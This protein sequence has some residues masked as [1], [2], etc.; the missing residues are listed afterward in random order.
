MSALPPPGA[1]RFRTPYLAESLQRAY[2]PLPTEPFHV[3]AAT[4]VWL[5]GKDAAEPGFYRPEKTPWT[6]RLQELDRHPFRFVYDFKAGRWVSVR[7][8]KFVAQKSSRTGYTEGVFNGLRWRAVYRPCNYIIAI[9]TDTQAK[10]IAAR[11]LRSLK[12]LRNLPGD[13][14]IFTGNPDD[15]RRSAFELRG[16][17]ADFY[18]SGSPGNFANKPAQRVLIDEYDEHIPSK[19]DTTSA[20]NLASRIKDAREGLLFIISKPQL[21][22][23]PI[24]T[25][26]KTG[27]CEEFFVPCPHCRTY[28]PITFDTEDLDTDF[29]FSKPFIPAEDEPS[30]GRDGA[31]R[32]SAFPEACHWP[33]PSPSDSQSSAPSH[34]HPATQHSAH[35]D[36]Q[37]TWLPHPFPP[38][39][40]AK[41]RTGR[42]K[43]DH[44]KM[45]VT[46]E[47]DMLA[48]AQGQAYYECCN[49]HCPGGDDGPRVIRESYKA[50]MAAEGLWL[51][52]RHGSPSVV[53]Q[54]MH[55]LLSPEAKS[56]WGDII[57]EFIEKLAQGPREFQG[58][59]NNRLGKTRKVEANE[60]KEADIEK[61]IAGAEPAEPPPDPTKPA[62]PKAPKLRRCAPYKRGDIPF[63][64]QCLILGADV[65]LDYAVWAMGAL[66]ENFED[67]AM[68]DWGCETGPEVIAEI[69]LRRTWALRDEPGRK[70]RIT[71]GFIDSK[72]RK[73]DVRKASWSVF[74]HPHMRKNQQRL[75][76]I[77]GMP[78]HNM[79]KNDLTYGSVNGYPPDYKHL[80]FRDQE[81][82]TELYV[83]RIAKQL[84]RL[85]FPTDVMKVRPTD[86]PMHNFA[87]EMCGEKLIIPPMG[88]AHWLEPSPK[89]NHFGDCAK[90][91]TLGV[92]MLTR[93]R[94]GTL[95]T[96][97]PDEA[98]P[99]TAR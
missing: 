84:R 12:N 73:S 27:N 94:A 25:E 6:R 31:Q 55:D 58:F 98:E 51:P 44:C 17:L 28:Q 45:H 29:D 1:L 57:Q 72:H 71:Y 52:L 24:N 26:W 34:P 90:A 81:A 9:D 11:V 97:D 18:G 10:L 67:V 5:E 33:S 32:D 2:A 61:N 91:I 95:N 66:A 40:R 14:P 62:D 82:K 88:H 65:G 41:L 56:S 76:T 15:L 23:G 47:W 96:P 78:G 36:P 49:E 93:L 75:I 83:T 53:S 39:T 77:S 30:K 16:M 8:H 22:N 7:I 68:I 20:N 87:A 42:L 3:W 37:K 21:E 64:P 43:F 13:R 46:G 99:A 79:R 86:D 59:L 48:L 74:T 35:Y 60:T 69:M 89:P 4:H 70:F 92:T 19:T 54:H 85:W 38:G 63:V 80:S 50:T